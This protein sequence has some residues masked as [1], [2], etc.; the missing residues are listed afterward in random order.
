MKSSASILPSSSF[1]SASGTGAD[2]NS[3]VDFMI[4]TGFSAASAY[5]SPFDAISSSVLLALSAPSLYV[6]VCLS[7]KALMFVLATRIE[8]PPEPL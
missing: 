3:F 4:V 7:S 1:G 6:I 2:A 8:P 5:I